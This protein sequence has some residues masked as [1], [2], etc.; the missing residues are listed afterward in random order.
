MH[1]R[2]ENVMAEGER[3]IAVGAQRKL[4]AVELERD[5]CGVA[6][7]YGL[8]KE[9][10]DIAMA[11]GNPLFEDIRASPGPESACDSETCRWMLQ[12]ATGKGSVHP[13]ELL[14]RSYGL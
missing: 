6:G 4:R 5:C 13:I 3:R 2:A 11:V 1:Q 7:T 14:H 12:H 9:K 8:K 10:Y